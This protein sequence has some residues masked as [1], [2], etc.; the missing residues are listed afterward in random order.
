MKK[1]FLLILILLFS[2][3]CNSDEDDGDAK[4]S[5]EYIGSV[6]MKV[7]GRA[8]TLKVWG[9]TI[10]YGGNFPEQGMLGFGAV[11]C[12]N[13]IDLYL[14]LVNDLGEQEIIPD[15]SHIRFDYYNQTGCG[16]DRDEMDQTAP[17]IEYFKN[18]SVE[19]NQLGER[20]KG[21]FSGITESTGGGQGHEIT[22]GSFE[23][24]LRD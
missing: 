23:F 8:Y 22:E 13:N 1:F 11:D 2:A 18:G 17:P 10:N 7:N 24:I 21:T 4:W 15:K 5:P 16:W 3:S 6:N 9:G 12:N 19:L 14:N 20:Y